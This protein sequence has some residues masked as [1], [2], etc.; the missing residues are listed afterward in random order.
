MKTIYTLM[1]LL[2]TSPAMAEDTITQ[3]TYTLAAPIISEEDH[4]PSLVPERVFSNGFNY[5]RFT[6]KG[7]AY[8]I[9]LDESATFEFTYRFND[10]QATL[11]TD[12][13]FREPI[14]KTGFMLET[15]L[16]QSINL[17]VGLI[18]EKEEPQ[19]FTGLKIKF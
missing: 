2:T 1:H 10:F 17:N 8:S 14:F 15:A 12:I 5:N 9:P 6:F 18:K 11:L 3:P 16:T 19:Y 7:V 4:F 13:S